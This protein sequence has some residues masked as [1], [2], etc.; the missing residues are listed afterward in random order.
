[1]SSSLSNSNPVKSTS[2]RPRQFKTDLI[3]DN[4]LAL[5]WKKGFANTTTRELE[6]ELSLNQSSLYNSFG[7]KAE[8]FEAVLDRYEMLTS[9]TLIEPLE[10]SDDGIQSIKHFFYSLFKWVTNDGRRGCLLINLMAEDGGS[11]KAIL[12]RTESYRNRVK[13]A[14]FTALEKAVV[15]GEIS[16]GF[17][18]NRAMILLGLAL[19][20]NI[21]ARGGSSQEELKQLSDAIQYQIASWVIN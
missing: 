3:L 8:F 5:F 18:E 15:Q 19:G 14:I 21:A 13:Q 12:T 1:M 6:T 4:A 16:P 17:S 9:E 20:L 10:Q 7:S 11:N 2:G